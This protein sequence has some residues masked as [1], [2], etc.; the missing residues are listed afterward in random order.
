VKNETGV[1]PILYTYTDYAR[2]LDASVSQY[3]LW[4]AHWTCNPNSPP[5]TGIWPSWVFWQYYA[6]EYCGDNSNTIPGIDAV[7]DLDVFNGDMSRLETFLIAAGPSDNPPIVEAFNVSPDSVTLGDPFTISYKVSDDIG[8]KQV[9]LWRATDDNGDGKPDWPDD[10]E[11]YIDIH[12]LSAQ[13]SHSGD[14]ND[15]PSSV[16][17]YWYGLHVVDTAGQWSVEPDPPGP[18]QVTVTSEGTTP[19]ICVIELLQKD[20]IEPID[21]IAVDEWFDI[22]VGDSTDD[23]GISEVRFS[24]DES[25][26]GIPQGSWT[27]WYDWEVSDGPYTWNAMNKRM[28]WAFAT[29]GHKEVW[30]E[31]KDSEGQTSRCCANIRVPCVC[32]SWQDQGCGQGPCFETQMYETRTCDT[33]G[34]AVEERCITHM[35]CEPGWK[36]PTANG[37]YYRGWFN[38]ENAHS[39]DNRYAESNSWHSMQDWYN[40]GFNIPATSIIEGIEIKIEGIGDGVDY[41]GKV[42]VTVGPYYPYETPY[43]EFPVNQEVTYVVGGPSDLWGFWAWNPEYFKDNT[44]NPPPFTVEL[45]TGADWFFARIDSVQARVY[46]RVCPDVSYDY[47]G[48]ACLAKRWLEQCYF[49]NYYCDCCDMNNDEIIDFEDFAIFADHWLEGF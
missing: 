26:D 4:I 10:P 24:S 7:V 34:C 36:S 29:S 1:E 28:A 35:S 32:T 25:Q 14:F 43:L 22:Y 5:N 2:N 48:L 21:E 38:P 15:T 19:P 47:L 3:D 45:S 33:P 20:R 13:T 49:G 8:L 16:N 40:F 41:A 11:G 6:P 37:K 42:K 44:T 39:S 30:S 31:L 23:I 9:E 12:H 18:I 46:Y 27:E 17:T